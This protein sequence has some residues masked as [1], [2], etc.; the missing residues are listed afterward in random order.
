MFASK[1]LSPNFVFN[2]KRILANYSL[3]PMNSLEIPG[4]IEV[5]FARNYNFPTGNRSEITILPGAIE[6]KFARN[7]ILEDDP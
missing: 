6:V 5:K 3:F 4:V 1:G 7:Y 2:T